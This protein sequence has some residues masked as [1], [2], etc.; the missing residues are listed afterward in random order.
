MEVFSTNLLA[1][2]ELSRQMYSLLVKGIAPAIINVASVAAFFDVKTGTPYGMSK[3]ALLQ[4]TRNL[5]VEWAGVGIRVNAVSPWFTV[6]PLTKGYLAQK[7]R[8]EPVLKT[9]PLARVA[10]PEE[11]SGVIAFLAM[12]KASYITGQNI[13]VDG[14][15]S[16]SAF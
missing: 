14:G 16:V 2:F 9:T 7:E 1:P 6:T 8:M 10:Q 13:M 4:L 5:A 15:M 3:A 11:V 12:E